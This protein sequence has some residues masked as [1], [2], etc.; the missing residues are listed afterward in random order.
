MCARTNELVGF[1][2]LE[3]PINISTAVEEG[4]DDIEHEQTTSNINSSD[5]DNYTSS[6]NSSASSDEEDE[7]AFGFQKPVA[8]MIL[9]FFWSSIE[10]DF[11]WPVASF[12]LNNINANILS[13]CESSE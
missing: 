3:I 11:T 8:K 9:Q 6:E 13:K 12:P 7:N 4:Y 5:G 2:D 1:E 10:G